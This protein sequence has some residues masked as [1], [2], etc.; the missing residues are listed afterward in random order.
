MYASLSR[1]LKLVD[2]CVLEE[3]EPIVKL[4]SESQEEIGPDCTESREWR[5][6][7]A[8]DQNLA[9]QEERRNSTRSNRKWNYVGIP[10]STQPSADR[11]KSSKLPRTGASMR[12]DMLTS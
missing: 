3:T 7:N 5:N 12:Q 6:L 11:L 2:E 4:S 1:A 9:I 10:S 8:D